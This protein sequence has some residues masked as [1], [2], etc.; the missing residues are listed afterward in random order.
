MAFYGVLVK[1]NDL[2]RIVLYNT[3]LKATCDSHNNKALATLLYKKQ[4]SY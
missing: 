1:E 2:Y 4:L 3:R